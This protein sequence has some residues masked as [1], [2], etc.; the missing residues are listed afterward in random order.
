MVSGVLPNAANIDKKLLVDHVGVQKLVTLAMACGGACTKRFDQGSNSRRAGLGGI[1][2]VDGGVCFAFSLLWASS[3]IQEESLWDNIFSR[4][5]KVNKD[6]GNAMVDLQKEYEMNP[7]NDFQLL[8]IAM[9]GMGYIP[10]TKFI[11]GSSRLVEAGP[12][13]THP[14]VAASI[15]AESISSNSREGGSYKF[16]RMSRTGEAHITVAWVAEDVAFFDPNYGEFWFET[17]A[18]FRNWFVEY[19]GSITDYG[20]TF[21][22]Y[23]IST[24]AKAV[25]FKGFR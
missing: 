24:F 22:K 12:I 16:F 7:K 19:W 18:G 9:E 4:N 17:R 21:N 20:W 10:T 8:K 6:D 23:N 3:H 15:L 14:R 2:G 5:N 13:M 25:S 11:N 1:Q